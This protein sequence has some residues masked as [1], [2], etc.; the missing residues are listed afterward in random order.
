MPMVRSRAPVWV[1]APQIEQARQFVRRTGL[2]KGDRCALLANNSIRWVA[3][4]LALMAE[5]VIVV[6][7]Y[8][9]QAAGE[10]V[11]MVR[12][13]GPSL[14]CAGDANLA[15]AVRAA[16]PGGAGPI[17][18]IALFDEIFSNQ[19]ATSR[20]APVPTQ[21][22]DQDVVTIIYTS[23]T[24]GEPKG[25]MLH[26]GNVTYML[27]CTGAR[28]DLL[29]AGHR[30]VEIVFHYL[31]L[32]FAGSWI[33]LLS[34]LSR[35]TLVTLSTDLNRL[36]QEMQVAAS[37]YFLN[38]PTLLERVRRGIEENL[39]KRGGLVAKIFDRA[40]CFYIPAQEAALDGQK[41]SRSGGGICLAMAKLAVFPSIRKRIGA[42]LKALI[43]GSA[44]LSR[45]TQLFFQM[46]GIPVL[47][48]Y[49]LT[50]TTAICTMD[51]PRNVEPG[52]VG[53]AIPGIEMKVGDAG[54][55]L[56]RGAERF[57]WLLESAPGNGKGPSRRLV[58]HRRS[59][60]KKF[61][62]KLADHRPH[63]ESDHLEFWTQYRARADGG[64]ASRRHSG[65]ATSGA[66]GAWPEFPN[67]D[68]HRR[69]GPGTRRG[70]GGI[71]QRGIAALPARPPLLHR[72][73]T[74]LHRK[75][76]ADRQWKIAAR[77]DCVAFCRAN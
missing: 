65:R 16:W 5:G 23:G 74:A 3:L 32:C 46:L 11:G 34:G 53:P 38:V 29:M 73:R 64:K 40:K 69:H 15:E 54:E 18:P 44:P 49:G 12:D 68:R 58:P 63:Q 21:L 57:P 39:A 19:G 36:Q 27:G 25:V 59:G 67:S 6:P 75:W 72:T 4:D 37:H 24:S 2:Q 66:G 31:P 20:S 60:R 62:W 47:Q 33:S 1:F 17:P 70:R 8:A 43:C 9:R 30:G 61:Q 76:H 28:L 77:R 51:D 56:V 42:N 22:S 14:I 26:S 10:L 41:R 55:I 50:E 45:E 52:W 35:Q 7:L 48:V 71:L 13:A